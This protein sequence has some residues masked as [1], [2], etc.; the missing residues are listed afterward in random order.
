MSGTVLFHDTGSGSDSTGKN[1]TSCVN[2][3]SKFVVLVVEQRA[4]AGPIG[5]ADIIG[6]IVIGLLTKVSPW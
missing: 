5:V 4:G 1:G 3:L 6:M 2:A